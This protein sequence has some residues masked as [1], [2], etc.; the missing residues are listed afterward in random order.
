[1]D[2][3][4]GHGHLARW[5]AELFGVPAIGL[6]RI[7]A[8]VE[9]AQ[10]LL[11]TGAGVRF[12]VRDL[13]DE[14]WPL[15]PGDLAVGLHACGEL[16]DATTMAAARAGCDLALVSCCY[17]K[18][19][20]E[21][22]EPLSAPL[23]QTD[24]VLRRE[25]LGLANL[26]SREQGVAGSITDMMQARR[27]RLALRLLLRERGVALRPGDEMRGI[28]RR[29]AYGALENLAVAALRAREL[30]GPGPSEIERAAREARCRFEQIRRFSL[31][32]NM[33]APLLEV[34]IALDRASVLAEHG[35][36][37]RVVRVFAETASPRNL[38][39]VTGR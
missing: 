18:I 31:P 28:N 1:V 30:P 3:G 12:Q 36:D 32:R 13:L 27:S 35:L 33:L 7:Q 38:A 23:R 17:Q 11:P 10:R 24:L 19:R 5:V 34:L 2:V 4:S 6:E 37:A 9:T 39:V 22:R 21:Q 15:R 20:G 25:V 26:A 29:R 16:S 8:R 14:P